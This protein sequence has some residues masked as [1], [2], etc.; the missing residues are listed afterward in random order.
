MNKIGDDYSDEMEAILD[1]FFLGEYLRPRMV[2]VRTARPLVDVYTFPPLRLHLEDA[3]RPTV[4][5]K[6]LAPD[7]SRP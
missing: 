6:G 5:R 3:L 4:T 1:A 7:V 2:Q